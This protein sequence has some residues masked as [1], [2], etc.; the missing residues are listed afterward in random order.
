MN[1][2]KGSSFS[3][4]V[5]YLI[6]KQRWTIVGWYSALEI[7][8]RIV[9]TEKVRFQNGKRGCVLQ[10]I[11]TCFQRM[12]LS[13]VDL[14]LP[15]L[16]S[17]YVFALLARTFIDIVVSYVAEQANFYRNVWL[18][19][20]VLITILALSWKTADGTTWTN[21]RHLELKRMWRF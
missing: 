10:R 12:L 9:E 19:F 3:V 18:Y 21:T 20:A 16:C 5:F 6:L 11:Y 17:R 1:K 7:L 13:Q 4:I 2:S 15:L 14:F 8:Q